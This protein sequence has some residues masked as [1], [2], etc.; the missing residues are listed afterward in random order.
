MQLRVGSALPTVPAWSEA[1]HVVALSKH[2][3]AKRRSALARPSDNTQEAV[4][5]YRAAS[6]PDA[7]AACRAAFVRES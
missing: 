2:S 7:R 1:S 3:H 4:F 5:Y 6:R